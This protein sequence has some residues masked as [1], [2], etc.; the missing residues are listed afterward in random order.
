MKALLTAIKSKLQAE[1]SYVKDRDVYVTEDLRLV[2]SSG[3]YP[4][5]ALK[6]DGISFLVEAGD[7]VGETLTV[8]IGCYVKLHKPEAAVMGDDPAGEKG[9]LDIA[10]DVITSTDSTLGGIV[11]LSEPVGI[12]GSEMLFDERK[13]LQFLP[14]T[15]RYSRWR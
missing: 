12:N 1:I 15:M 2:R 13:G 11:D 10:G 4:A 7:Q 8:K 6:D 5:L 14:V 9:L 3:G